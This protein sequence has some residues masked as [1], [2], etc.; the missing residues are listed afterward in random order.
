MSA[1]VSSLP[2]DGEVFTARLLPLG[3]LA[4]M[5]ATLAPRPIAFAQFQMDGQGKLGVLRLTFDDGQAHEFRREA[6]QAALEGNASADPAAQCG[7][8]AGLVD[9]GRGRKMEPR[10]EGIWP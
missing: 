9:I 5:A 7:D 2:W 6:K 8:F 4:V 1:A 3:R 10:L